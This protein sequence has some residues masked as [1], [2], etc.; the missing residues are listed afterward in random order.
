MH[1]A[2]GDQGHIAT[3][4]RAD[5]ADIQRRIN[6]IT[7][8]RRVGGRL[9]QITLSVTARIDVSRQRVR[10]DAAAT[11]SDDAAR[12]LMMSW[13]ATRLAEP[14]AS[15]MEPL[16]S[17]RYHRDCSDQRRWGNK[18]SRLRAKRS[19]AQNP[20]LPRRVKPTSCY[21]HPSTMVVLPKMMLRP[22]SNV[23]CPLV[24][25][26]LPDKSHAV[27]SGEHDIVKPPAA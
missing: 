5:A 22:A 8:R 16:G 24:F 4:R 21:F 23:S 19:S 13:P 14:E 3:R 1:I 11:C 27:P 17:E 7:T 18:L 20:S 12:A 15:M 2:A 10:R 26:V 25:P 9:E 6:I